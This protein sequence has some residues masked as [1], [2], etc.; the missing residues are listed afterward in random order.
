MMP[1]QRD[2]I[3]DIELQVVRLVAAACRCDPDAVALDSTFD[4][5]GLKSLA[6]L[7]LAFEI[8]SKYGVSIPD[9]MAFSFKSVREVVDALRAL[10]SAPAANR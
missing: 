9:D 10:K 6:A 1:A 8:E 7:E 5:L 4:Q 2:D 3:D